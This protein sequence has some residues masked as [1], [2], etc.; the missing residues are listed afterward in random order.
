MLAVLENLEKILKSKRED[1]HARYVALDVVRQQIKA[2]K[3]E[4]QAESRRAR[5][6]RREA[7]R[8]LA[9]NLI[10]G[11]AP[12]INDLRKLN[13]AQRGQIINHLKQGQKIQAIKALRVALG[14]GL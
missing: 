3:P 2:L 12:A 7:K 6:K 13:N 14:I 11:Y 4:K 8:Q 9:T 5:A 1:K 10:P